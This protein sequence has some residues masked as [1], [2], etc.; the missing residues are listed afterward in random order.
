MNPATTIALLQALTALAQVT[1]KILAAM[2]ADTEPTPEE[3]AWLD[4]RIL[5]ARARLVK[6]SMPRFPPAS[7]WRD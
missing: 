7:E 1:T 6:A 5:S 2:E 4:E 3:S